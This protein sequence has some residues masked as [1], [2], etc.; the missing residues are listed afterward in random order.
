VCACVYV[1]VCCTFVR[2]LGTPGLLLCA[3][4]LNQVCFESSV[5]LCA[6]QGRVSSVVIA[7]FPRL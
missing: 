5:W 3:G 1:H 2:G 4:Y 6:P 7:L